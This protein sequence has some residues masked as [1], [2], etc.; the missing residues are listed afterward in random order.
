[1]APRLGPRNY[2]LFAQPGAV[3]LD[4]ELVFPA[5]GE[6]D[7]AALLTVLQCLD[8]KVDARADLITAE[9]VPS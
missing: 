1:M 8:A 3:P 5:V 6:S 4:L 2:S 9:S 7:Y